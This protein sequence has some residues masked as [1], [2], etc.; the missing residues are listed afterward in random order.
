MN[1]ILKRLKINERFTKSL[2]ITFDK[3]VDN[4][5]PVGGYNYMADLLFLPETKNKYKYLLTI[6]DIWSKK[7]DFETIANKQ[8]RTV[9]NA[10]LKIFKRGI[11]K[12]PKASIRTDSGTEFKS[13][14]HK[15]L[16]DNGIFHRVAEP[17]R[18]QQMGNIEKL[19]YDL[20]RVINGYLNQKEQE[21]GK[22][23]REWTDILDLIRT[24]LNRSKSIRKDKN[25]Y[26]VD[27][28]EVKLNPKYKVG[29]LV[30]YR[31]DVPLDASGNKQPT[32]KFRV[33]DYRY[34]VFNPRKIHSILYYPNNIRYLLEGK[35]NVSYAESELLP[36]KKEEAKYIVRKIIGKKKIKN[37]VH[38]F[39]WWKGYLKKDATWEPRVQL[40]ED[41]LKDMVNEYE[42]SLNKK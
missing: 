4:T 38:Y 19:N 26:K 36:A 25:V 1:K 3:V 24:E 22:P 9:L 28:P 8:P 2:K 20:G 7:C 15:W 29:D 6:I 35:M 16:N 23:Y 32:T 11:L 40:L 33:G 5:L 31:S 39:V 30:L 37:R 14:F 18:H 17:Y 21:T 12:Q 27:F 42:R 34:N 41:G 13:V 10:M